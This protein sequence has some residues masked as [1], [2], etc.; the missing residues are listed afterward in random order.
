MTIAQRIAATQTQLEFIGRVREFVSIVRYV[1]LRRNPTEAV[2]LAE[3]ERAPASVLEAIKAA[4]DPITIGGSGLAP[5]QTQ[6]TAFFASMAHTAAF[7][8]ML[9]FMVQLPLRTRA[10]GITSVITGGSSLT[11]TSVKPVGRMSLS[12]ADLDIAK[13]AAQVV[14]TE[15]LLRGTRG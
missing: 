8:A 9:P 15:E 3:Q 11:E 10:V 4:Q 1:T 13:A 2:A 7:D 5:F 6:A 12:A 14:V